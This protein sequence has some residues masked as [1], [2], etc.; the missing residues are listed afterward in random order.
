MS[1]P[2]HDEVPSSWTE[3][4]GTGS[5]RT[6]R[7]RSG[8][9]WLVVGAGLLAL[10]LFAGGF[11]AGWRVHDVAASGQVL[12]EPSVVTVTA[13]P[14][15]QAEALMPDVRG[16]GE[17]TARQVL[18]DAGVTTTPTVTEKPWAGVAGVVVEQSPVFG[19]SAPDSV[20]LTVSAPALV[21]ATEGRT[22]TDVA[23]EVSS[24]GAQ[25]TVARRY[26]PGAAPGSV[27]AIDPT[28]GAAL[29]PEVTITEAQAAESRYLTE[30]K[31]LEGGCS[32]REVKIS[33]PSYPHGLVCE[34]RRSGEH[35]WLLSRD[36][37]AVTGLFGIPDT[38]DPATTATVE[39]LID[40]QPVQTANLTYGADA[41]PIDLTTTG[42]LRLAVRITTE[43]PEPAWVGFGDV[44][45]VGDGAA[46]QGLAKR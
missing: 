20:T 38:A 19:T 11:T 35:V 24:L 7:R 45:L 23:N 41:I 10:A 15:S 28:P 44:R 32:V 6:R 30:V 27:L 36:V 9:R 25:V 43:S 1:Q 37:D 4:H 46:L 40:G 3:Q 12:P 39:I 26:Q 34:E 29:P 18:A 42:A 33:G 17:A 16:L 14:A 8:V 5:D 21:P 22:A 2:A 31:P 13:L